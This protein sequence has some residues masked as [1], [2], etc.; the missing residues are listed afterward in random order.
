MNLHLDTSD[1]R[2]TLGEI[3]TQQFPFAASQAHNDATKAL[4]E[5]ERQAIQRNFTIN[6]SKLPFMLR[7]VKVSEFSNK[8]Q[9]PLRSVLEV[10]DPLSLKQGEGKRA[11]LLARHEEGGVA[12]SSRPDFPLAIPTDEIRGGAY[13]V[14]PRNLYPSSLRLAPRRT[15]EG[16][17]APM[18]RATKNGLGMQLQGKRRTFVLD[19]RET[20]AGAKAWGIYQRVGRGASSRLR[21]IWAFRSR[22]TLRPRLHFYETGEK[23]FEQLFTDALP[24][25][26]DAAVRTAKPR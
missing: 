3:A 20:P 9:M 25:R 12:R 10:A 13:D 4:Q 5:L 2:A 11:Q 17:L 1:L 14:A 7:M 22:I 23:H 26:L 15:P 16:V 6:P 24:A 18:G 8:K 19:T 21:M